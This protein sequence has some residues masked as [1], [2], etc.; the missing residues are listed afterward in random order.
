MNK[1]PRRK[2]A[3]A[4]YLLSSSDGI[5][6]QTNAFTS[7][8]STT[9]VTSCRLVWIVVSR[10]H[11]DFLVT[12][13][14]KTTAIR[15]EISLHFHKQRTRSDI[16]DVNTDGGRLRPT[17][18]QWWLVLIYNHQSGYFKDW[19]N[20]DFRLTS[21]HAN[22]FVSFEVAAIL[23]TIVKTTLRVVGETTL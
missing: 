1:L 8:T 9:T 23:H 6:F 7:T 11:N 20:T 4:T 3:T 18:S 13:F 19:N 5:R 21:L 14:L 12:L 2:H 15:T 10:S 17:L 16:A 22:H